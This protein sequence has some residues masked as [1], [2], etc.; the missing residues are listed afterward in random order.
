MIG[1]QYT[2]AINGIVISAQSHTGLKVTARG[3]PALLA[4]VTADGE[5]VAVGDLVAK[6]AEAVAINAYR[7]FLAGK[8]HLKVYSRP[9]HEQ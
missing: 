6:E 2:G 1:P 5:I 4:V 3:E 8:G 7:N 9:L